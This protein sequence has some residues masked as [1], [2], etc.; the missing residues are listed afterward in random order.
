MTRLNVC[1][2]LNKK[3]HYVKVE[4]DKDWADIKPK[5]VRAK[6]PEHAFLVGYCPS[7]YANM[8]F[9][10]IEDYNKRRLQ[11]DKRI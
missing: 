2:T 6:I 11:N 5:D 4:L 10:E 1:Y 3:T 7:E 8:T 9:Q